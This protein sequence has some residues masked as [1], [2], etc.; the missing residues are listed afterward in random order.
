LTT[1]NTDSARRRRWAI[2]LTTAAVVA[3]SLVAVTADL[4]AAQATPTTQKKV[5]VVKVVSRKHFGNILATVKGEASLY[6]LPKGSCTGECLMIWPPLT[7]KKGSTATPT[8]AKCLATAKF[9]K[10]RQVTYRGH[11]LYTFT[12][13][14]GHSVN[15]NGEGGFAVAKVSTK[16]CPKPKKST[17]GG[18]GGGW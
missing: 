18:G 3:G 14:S 5:Q 7:M 2:R 9:N 17:G 13:D 8:G 11:R 10:L 15:G 1:G 4:P 12:G 6:Y 16:A